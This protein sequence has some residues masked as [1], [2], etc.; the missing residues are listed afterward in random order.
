MSAIRADEAAPHLTKSRKNCTLWHLTIQEL[1]I[2]IDALDECE[3]SDGGRRMLLSEVFNLQAKTGTCFFA[4][5]RFIPE[6]MKE[7]EGRRLLEIRAG[8][9]DVR[10]YIDAKMSRLRP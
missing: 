10:R 8:D 1:F 5:S 2:I 4:T 7:F 3:V 9:N 6:I